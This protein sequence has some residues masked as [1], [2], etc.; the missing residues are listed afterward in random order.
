MAVLVG[1]QGPPGR[2]LG[3]LAGELGGDGPVSG[4][5]AGLVVQA[6]QVPR[7]R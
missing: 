4:E 2:V 7:R 3:E 6:E 1:Q 5:V